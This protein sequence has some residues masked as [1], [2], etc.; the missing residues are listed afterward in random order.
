[1]PPGWDTVTVT[2]P[3]L[4][5]PITLTPVKKGATQSA[6]VDAPGTRHR[7]R[8]GLR[9]G[10]YPVT[11]T[12]HDRIVA[13]ARLKVAAEGSAET[14]RFVIGPKDAFPGSDVPAAVRP[15]GEVR[16]VLSDLR[17]APN[18]DSLTV[19][20]PIFKGPLTIRTDSSDDPGCK[21]DD[22][23]TVYAGH[24]RVR[25]DVPEGRYTLT[26]V[27]HGGRQTTTQRVTVAGKA[28]AHGRSWMAGGA[29]AAGSVALIGGA[30]IAARRRSHKAASRM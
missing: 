20:S 26:V 15:G 5:E 18:E 17:P 4:V 30:A 1:M 16:V 21:C 28:V 27:S 23:A 7:I 11:A 2:S 10:T 19:T 29:V 24:A 13:T 22:P 8:S 14:G 6:Q 25:D 3:A 9:A 12:S